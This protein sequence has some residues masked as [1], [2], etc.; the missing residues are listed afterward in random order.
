MFLGLSIFGHGQREYAYFKNAVKKQINGES[1]SLKMEVTGNSP[2]YVVS[3]QETAGEITG[4]IVG[5][6]FDLGVNLLEK[7]LENR[8]KSFSAEY[9]ARGIVFDPLEK[10]V[11]N[12]NFEWRLTGGGLENET[13]LCLKFVPK[14][15]GKKEIDIEDPADSTKTKK[16]ERFYPLAHYRLESFERNA[17]KA[18]IV[19]NWE[20]LD[21]TIQIKLRF[22]EFEAGQFKGEKEVELGPV[23]LKKKGFGSSTD[24]ALGTTK[25]FVLPNNAY[26]V[27]ADMTITETNPRRIR[28]EKVLQ[29]WKD[30]NSK[31]KDILQLYL[32][33][34]DSAG[35]SEEGQAPGE[36]S[37]K[38]SEKEK[39]PPGQKIGG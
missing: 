14:V 1:I 38:E 11:P 4:K 17:S 31:A 5:T 9:V 2:E 8:E 7:Y 37:V 13:A 16:V 18:R 25:W 22:I 34:S 36:E 21:Y 27:G 19:K 35:G 6:A 26:L 32:P 39:D 33:N 12:L 23:T 24:D 29:A 10:K 30:H 3:K 20:L 28:A 15:I